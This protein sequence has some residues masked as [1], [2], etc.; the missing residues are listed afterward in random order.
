MNFDVYNPLQGGWKEAITR[1]GAVNADINF[2]P[3]W[4]LTWQDY[5]K[6]DSRCIVAEIE[7]ITLIY[8]FLMRAIDGYDTPETW[9]DIQTAYGYGGVISDKQDVPSNILAKFNNAVTDWL[10]ENRVVAEFIR[11]HPQLDHNRRDGQYVMVRRNVYVE[12]SVD[13]RIPEAKTR[14]HISK[15]LREKKIVIQ[16]DKNLDGLSEFVR[17]YGLNA[18]RIG[19][20]KYYFFPDSYFELVKNHLK[21]NTV[22]FH[23]LYENR[24]INS[25]MYF[26][27]GNKATLHLAGADGEYNKL[28][29]SDL[30]YYSTVIFSANLGL[31]SVNFGGGTSVHEDDSLFRY[32]KKFSNI[33]KDVFI[34]KKIIKQEAYNALVSQW[35]GKY[36]HLK[37]TYRN[38][39]LKYRQ[40]E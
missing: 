21:D 38:F 35:E 34:G 4:Y 18:H 33:Y 29:G 3:E 36:P 31:D 2:L 10:Y 12:P 6:S 11:E 13:Y 22:L 17:L 26:H 37:D 14:Q 15:I 7:G 30:I 1:V 19:M 23:V 40:E 28:K 20:N 16:I 8:P 27:F 32:K 9:Y 24:V 25:L 5:E 39:F